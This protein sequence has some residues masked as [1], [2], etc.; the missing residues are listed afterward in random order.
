MSHYALR[1]HLAEVSTQ[2]DY[3]CAVLRL[4]PG[5][6]ELDQGVLTAEDPA[7][8]RVGA[9]LAATLATEA[10]RAARDTARCRSLW[11]LVVGS[12]LFRVSW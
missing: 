10:R 9:E 1:T 12:G 2:D 5:V 4:V 3:R 11:W 6:R 8:A 7:R